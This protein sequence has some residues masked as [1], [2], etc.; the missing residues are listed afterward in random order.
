MAVSTQSTLRECS[1]RWELGAGAPAPVPPPVLSFHP[2]STPRAVAREAG[3]GWCSPSSSSS[4][5]PP[6]S[7]SSRSPAPSSSSFRSPAPL[8]VLVLFP[9]ISPHRF[10]PPVPPSAL[11]FPHSCT[12]YSR[13]WWGV[14]VVGGVVAGCWCRGGPGW[15]VHFVVPLSSS[16]VVLTRLGTGGG[17][18]GIAFSTCRSR[19]PSPSVVM[20]IPPTIHPRAV[21]CGAGGGWCV[22]RH[23]E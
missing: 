22:V 23:R 5:S 3:G 14:L 4:R 6:S 7:L 21:A 18:G 1:Q 8:L 16:P 12:P 20:V 11:S 10:G 17:R 13:W 15:H 19:L 9:I 2:L